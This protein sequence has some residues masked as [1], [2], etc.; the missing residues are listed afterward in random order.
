[1]G[2]TYVAVAAQ[3]PIAKKVRIK[4]EV[5]VHRRMHKASVAE[6]DLAQA[7][8]LGMATGEY[9]IHPF[10]DEELPIWI[11]NF[12]LMDYGSGAVMA[13]PG[14]DQRDWEFATQYSLPIQ[15]V[16]K[17]ITD[18]PE[19]DLGKQAWCE[20]TGVT[21]NSAQFDG[22]NFEDDETVAT[23]LEIWALVASLPTTVP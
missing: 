5:A 21:I 14:H 22:L 11:A 10:T 16:I 8:K 18:D 1:M 17:P 19:Y 2:I 13:V 20:K 4:P 9:V 15:A 7:P 23:A 3:H 12:V 6:A